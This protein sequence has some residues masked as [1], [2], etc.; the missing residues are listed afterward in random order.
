MFKNTQYFLLENNPNIFL[1]RLK[2]FCDG[3]CIQEFALYFV[4][5]NDDIRDLCILK[6]GVKNKL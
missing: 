1:L 6:L 2:N 5:T 4:N 3:I